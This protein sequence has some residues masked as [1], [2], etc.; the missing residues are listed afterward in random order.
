[1]DQ[2]EVDAVKKGRTVCDKYNS[3][4]ALEGKLT[5]S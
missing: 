2:E 1:M 5:E 3:G 4:D